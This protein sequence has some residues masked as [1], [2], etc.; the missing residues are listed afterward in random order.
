[1]RGSS[2]LAG[3]SLCSP[4]ERSLSLLSATD[5]SCCHLQKA[6]NTHNHTHTDTDSERGG[7]GGLRESSGETGGE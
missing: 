4:Q 5:L 6:S 2:C 7:G 1:M 3:H